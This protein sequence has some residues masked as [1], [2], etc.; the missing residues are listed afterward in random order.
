MTSERART[1]VDQ[2][3]S[4]NLIT[5]MNAESTGLLHKD[6][7]E[8]LEEIISQLP[9]ARQVTHGD[10]KAIFDLLDLPISHIAPLT[11][12][13]FMAGL[14]GNYDPATE[15]VQ[16]YH[17]RDT[18]KFKRQGPWSLHRGLMYAFNVPY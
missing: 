12:F 14:L 1:A 17:R 18:Y 6:I 3:A 10:L 5:V 16:F 13:L 11:E 2:F 8:H 4:Q 9:S 7:Y 15:Y